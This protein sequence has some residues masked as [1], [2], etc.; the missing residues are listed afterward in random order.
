M[1]SRSRRRTGCP[2]P[3]PRPSGPWR[4]G[5]IPV[6][7]V[8]GGIGSGK[9]AAAAVLAELGGFVIDA[10]A[11]GHALLTQRPVRDEVVARFGPRVRGDDDRGSP[12]IDRRV[13]GSLVF[14]DPK[15][16]RDLETMLHPRMRRTFARAIA[17]TV[18]RG[19]AS[20]VVL[21]AAVLYEAGWDE[22]CDRVV[23]V[24]APR[25]QRLARVESGRG[26]N[27]EVLSAREQA[28]GP[29]DEKKARADAVVANTGDL[30]ALR[31]EVVRVWETV[32]RPARSAPCRPPGGL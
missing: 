30:D 26:W 3:G 15:A 14:N 13:L 16:R 11:V 6:V 8:V 4:H 9:S 18:R 21:D 29:L 24:D 1:T 7:G 5:P 17:R 19:R 20:A 28:Q 22:L 27:E 32:R 31:A 12:V 10:D 2:R 23:F 25:D